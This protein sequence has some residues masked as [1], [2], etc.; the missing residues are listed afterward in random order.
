MV[1]FATRC[2]LAV[3]RGARVLGRLLTFTT[4][5]FTFTATVAVVAR[6]PRVKSFVIVVVIV[7]TINPFAFK[8]A[9]LTF[10]IS[11]TILIPISIPIAIV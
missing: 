11:V 10:A 3:V 8:V 2:S 4:V 6:A 5:S 9:G 1:V 7:R